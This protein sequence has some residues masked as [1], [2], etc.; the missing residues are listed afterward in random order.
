[1]S[2]VLPIDADSENTWPEALLRGLDAH[3]QTIADFQLERGLLQRW[4]DRLD[5]ALFATLQQES[6]HL[7]DEQRYPAGAHHFTQAGLTEAAIEW[8]GKAGRRSLERSALVEAIEHARDPAIL[9][10]PNSRG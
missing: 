6:P 5:P 9:D 1:M 4:R 7:L 2:T 8:W 3:R 10:M